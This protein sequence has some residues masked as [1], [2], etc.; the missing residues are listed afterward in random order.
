MSPASL[1]TWALPRLAKLLPLDDDSLKQI[2]TYTATLSKEE[3]ADHLRNLLDDSA[4]SLEFISGFNSRRGGEQAQ[5][6]AGPQRQPQTRTQTGR[7]GNGSNASNTGPRNSKKQKNSIHTPAAVRRPDGHGNVGGGYVKSR[8][9]EDYIPGA[10]SQPQIS[11]SPATSA[12]QQSSSGKKAGKA[13][14]S[15]SGQL[16]SEYLPNVRS[17]K[18]KATGANAVSRGGNTQST[19]ATGAVG[20]STTTSNISD[21]T[22]AIAA[23]EVSTN[24]KDRKQRKCNCSATIHPL[25]TPAPNCLYCGKIICALEGLQPCSF[26]GTPLLSTTEMQDMIQELRTERGNEKMRAHNESHQRDSGSGPMPVDSSNSPT[27]NSK[28]EAAKAHRDKLLAFQSQNAQR[29]RIVDEAADFDIPTSASTQWMTPAQ[30]A[31]ALK[32]QQRLLREMEEKNRPEWEKKSVVLSL[33]IKKGKVVRTFEKIETPRTPDA[34]LEEEVDEWNEAEGAGL[35]EKGSNGTFSRNPLLK[36]AGL[37]RPVWK[38]AASKNSGDDGS[39]SSQTTK[40]EQRQAW[41]RVQDD[42][43]DNEKWILDGGLRGHGDNDNALRCNELMS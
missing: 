40:R 19:K 14:P 29:T 35:S 12:Q 20:A 6:Q 13:P 41:R 43:E 33:D 3:S 5:T 31:L 39:G 8:Q 1:E 7:S 10:P 16:I 21:L 9:A 36:G 25:F 26:C 18:A 15:A 11:P 4:A 37:V 22:A 23:L 34:E 32:K 28:L 2:I 38:P 30:R 24:P 17:K 27:A 42:N